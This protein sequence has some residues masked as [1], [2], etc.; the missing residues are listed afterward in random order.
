[1]KINSVYSH[2]VL[3]GLLAFGLVNVTQAQVDRSLAQSPWQQNSVV[4]KSQIS[5][6]YT[7][8]WAKADTKKVCPILALPK[9]SS[10]HKAS[11]KARSATFAGGWGVAYDT[12]SLRSAYG[13]ANAGTATESG[14]YAWDYKKRY[15][16]GSYVTYGHEG[17]DPNGKMLAYILLNNG[18]FYNVW[19]QYDETHLRKI[20]N[21]LHYVK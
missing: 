16:D 12:P 21:N 3:G 8:Q 17:G 10:A 19:S 20:I 9:Y 1:M 5:P 2:I 11:S 6:I 4:R 14:L 15:A 7:Q 18:C 13:V